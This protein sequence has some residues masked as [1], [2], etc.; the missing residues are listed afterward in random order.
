MKEINNRS[1]IKD[2]FKYERIKDRK[3]LLK[4]FSSKNSHSKLCE[5]SHIIIE[6]N[7]NSNDDIVESIKNKLE[8]E[9]FTVIKIGNRLYLIGNE[10]SML[11]EAELNGLIKYNQK[12]N[13]WKRFKLG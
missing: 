4:N 2:E 7:E 13:K 6:F 1:E 8:N 3:K 12:E 5:T 11:F 9:K 10:L